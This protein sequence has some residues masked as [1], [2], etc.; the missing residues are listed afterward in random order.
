MYDSLVAQRIKI[1]YTSCGE[2]REYKYTENSCNIE[3]VWG[4]INK[5]KDS[6]LCKKPVPMYSKLFNTW[7]FQL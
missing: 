4:A 6:S 2:K 7:N 5:Q 3:R 1:L